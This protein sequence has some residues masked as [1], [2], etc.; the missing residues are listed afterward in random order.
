MPLLTKQH[1]YVPLILKFADFKH[2]LHSA[3]FSAGVLHKHSFLPFSVSTI[4]PACVLVQ[5][6]LSNY[7]HRWKKL[8]HL[9]SQP[10]KKIINNYNKK[11][12]SCKTHEHGRNSFYSHQWSRHNFSSQYKLEIN[13]NL[14]RMRRISLDYFCHHQGF[15]FTHADNNLFV[16][17]LTTSEINSSQHHV[18]VPLCGTLN[19]I[20]FT[21]EGKHM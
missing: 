10:D 4:D 6:Q 7:F 13:G 11:T 5:C 3:L 15:V 1:N 12:R 20:E 17:Q 9:Q 14:L 2:G 8:K 21:W 16:M 19:T 18:F